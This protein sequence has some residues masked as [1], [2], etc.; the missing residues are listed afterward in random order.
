[1]VLHYLPERPVTP[2]PG[3]PGTVG[4]PRAGF[5][6]GK[7]VGNSVVRHRVTRQ[8]R[9]VVRADLEGVRATAYP[10]GLVAALVLR[11][12][13]TPYDDLGLDDPALP[14]DALLDAIERHP[15]LLERPIVATPEGVRLCRPAETVLDLLGRAAQH[16]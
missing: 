14:D 1:M 10:P 13:G 2:T 11:R 16:P 8:L 9:A 15:I 3:D 12:K 5:V 6:V 7:A 4:G